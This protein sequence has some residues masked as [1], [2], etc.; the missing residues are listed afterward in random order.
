MVPFSDRIT[1]NDSR[2]FTFPYLKMLRNWT[3]SCRFGAAPSVAVRT[4]EASSMTRSS[5]NGIA[6]SLG[7]AWSGGDV[8][9]GHGHTPKSLNETYP[10]AEIHMLLWLVP[11]NGMV[12]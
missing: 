5:V 9:N 7:S 12:N 11:K 1:S 10:S 4:L 8:L 2:V 6:T 3:T